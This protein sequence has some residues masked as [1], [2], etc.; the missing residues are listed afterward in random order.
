M[1]IN[2]SLFHLIVIITSTQKQN[3]KNLDFIL[4]LT[5]KKNEEKKFI[6]KSLAGDYQFRSLL[7]QMLTLISF[8]II[9]IEEKKKGIKFIACDLHIVF[10]L[11]IATYSFSS[12]LH[13]FSFISK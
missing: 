3:K 11:S 2:K 6:K 8:R 4:K 1:F 12:P 10:P 13:L 9:R 5:K 7:I